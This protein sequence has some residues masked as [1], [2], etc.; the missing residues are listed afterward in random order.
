MRASFYA[1]DAAILLNPIK[2]EV[3]TVFQILDFF[4]KVS[5]LKINLSK[6]TAFPIGCAAIDVPNIFADT[7]C[8]VGSLP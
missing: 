8:T 4:G 2:E 7:G 3:K 6:C 5:G 1:D